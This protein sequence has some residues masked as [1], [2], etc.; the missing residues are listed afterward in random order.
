MDV[1]ASQNARLKS[2]SNSSIYRSITVYPIPLLSSAHRIQTFRFVFYL[3]VLVPKVPNN[4]NTSEWSCI[5]LL[6][7]RNGAYVK[8]QFRFGF[9][10]FRDQYQERSIIPFC[11]FH[12][13]LKPLSTN[14]QR[15]RPSGFFN[16]ATQRA[17]S[18]P[19]AK[20]SMFSS[21]SVSKFMFVQKYA[22]AFPKGLE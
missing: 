21:T 15:Q 14:K 8:A 17:P 2:F 3:S 11:H 6:Q 9:L 5:C 7:W 1:Q 20:M 19:P 18:W 22:Q 16:M 10:R 4:Y 13:F 12:F